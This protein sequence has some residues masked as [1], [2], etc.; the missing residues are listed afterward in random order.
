LPSRKRQT[1]ALGQRK[2]EF[3]R[4]FFFSGTLAKL[5]FEKKAFEV[6]IVSPALMPETI[7]TR[8]AAREPTT[9]G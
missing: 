1:N 7:D 3:A 8:P 5:G 6:A 2:I 4:S 9:T